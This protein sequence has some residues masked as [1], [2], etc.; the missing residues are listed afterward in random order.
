MA[1]PNSPSI[2]RH[3][4][5]LRALLKLFR[6]NKVYRAGKPRVGER[7]ATFFL[8]LI[9]L[10]I[11][12]GF[13]VAASWVSYRFY[14]FILRS[15]YF[16]TTD[17]AITPLTLKPEIKREI[18]EKLDEEKIRGT[19]LLLLNTAQVRQALETIPKVKSA[20]LNKRYPD[21]LSVGVTLREMAGI[22]QHDPILAVD[23]EG[24]VI[25]QLSMQHPRILDFPFISGLQL[26]PLRLGDPIRSETLTR[27]LHLLSC[28]QNQEPLLFK[29]VSEVHCDNENGITL[30][31]RGGTEIRFGDGNP[32]QKMPA[33]ETFLQKVGAPEQFV[34][35]DLRFDGQV[36]Y[37]PKQEAAPKAAST[38][39]TNPT[40]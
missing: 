22:L 8:R 13:L 27:A 29:K 21:K 5:G 19:N 25:E 17:L 3:P 1:A 38:P 23:H 37:K 12:G 18:Q 36:P 39:K 2:F 35:I 30:L 15:D 10:V 28:L 9:A 26:G 14:Y 16:S 4:P 6:R 33:L 11:I 24:V 7:I 31:I 32:I 40:P 20:A 34:Y